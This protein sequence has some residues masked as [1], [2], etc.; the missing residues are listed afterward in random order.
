MTFRL[1]C[2]ASSE[3]QTS[4]KTSKAFRLRKVLI[5]FSFREVV[6]GAVHQYMM[7]C[8]K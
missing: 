8:V 4:V 2:A 7:V 3:A 5:A 6:G 1:S